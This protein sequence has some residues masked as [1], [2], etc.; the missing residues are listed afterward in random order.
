[1]S[2][3]FQNLHN[4]RKQSRRRHRADSEDQDHVL[5]EMMEDSVGYNERNAPSTKM[6][7]TSDD[8]E[9]EREISDEDLRYEEEHEMGESLISDEPEH[10]GSTILN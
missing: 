4:N 1:M 8:A 7:F 3:N 5:S 2:Y 6:R 9:A 10:F